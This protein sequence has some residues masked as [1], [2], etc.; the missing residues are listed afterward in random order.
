MDPPHKESVIILGVTLDEQL[1]MQVA[2]NFETPWRSCGVII[3]KTRELE[4]HL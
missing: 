1:D 2:D 3:P 4:L